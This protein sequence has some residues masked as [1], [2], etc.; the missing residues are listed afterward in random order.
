MPQFRNLVP[1]FLDL[2]LYISLCT[3]F[4]VVRS[5]KAV[6]KKVKKKGRTIIPQEVQDESFGIIAV[7]CNCHACGRSLDGEHF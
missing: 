5:L 7:C 1:I 2:R 6:L 4:E 3:S